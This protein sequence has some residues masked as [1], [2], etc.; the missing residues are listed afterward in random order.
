MQFD[1]SRTLWFE[2]LVGRRCGFITIMQSP[3]LEGRVDDI[4]Q[5]SELLLSHAPP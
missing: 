1:P 4:L 3:G 5:S 2:R